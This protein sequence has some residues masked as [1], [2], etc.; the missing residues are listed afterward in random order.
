MT[1]FL[2]IPK[3]GCEAGSDKLILSPDVQ[4]RKTIARAKNK[5]QPMLYTLYEIEEEEASMENVGII[6]MIEKGPELE[7]VVQKEAEAEMTNMWN[8]VEKKTGLIND[9]ETDM[10]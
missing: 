1:I 6:E 2:F 7:L 10:E 9:E 8:Q 3:E 4:S 5:K